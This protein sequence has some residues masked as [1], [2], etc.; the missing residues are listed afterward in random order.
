MLAGAETAQIQV[1][2]VLLGIH[3][4]LG[5]APLEH[6]QALLALGA[7]HDFS[8]AR[9]E[10]VH[11]GHGAPVVVEPH[12]EGLDVLRVIDHERRAAEVLLGE[13]PLVLSLQVDAP[14]DR[15]LEGA[16]GRLGRTQDVDG[17]GVGDARE[18]GGR[19]MVQPLQQP[20][21]DELVQHG[22]L[23]GAAFHH[24]ADDVLEHALGQ[25]HI[26]LKVGEGNLGLHHPELGGMARR[27]GILRAER[28]AERVHV[29]EG[30]GEVLGV[31]LAGHGERGGLAEEVG[32]PIH[33]AGHKRAVRGRGSLLAHKRYL[34]RVDGGHAEHLAGPLAVARR[35]DGRVHVDE[36]AVLE[37]AVD[38]GGG[39]RADAEHGA[40]Q[41]RARPQMLLGAQ[42]LRRGALLL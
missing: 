9:H 21:V 3:V 40:E 7:A 39:H 27:V 38:G 2:A 31:Q 35:D 4:Q 24:V 34:G 36:P 12:V 11:G 32:A 14:L 42:E 20:L 25:L 15:V 19:H 8:D 23:V 28:G 5:D 6:F 26:V 30:H 17:L 33:L 13:E 22:Q 41:V 10:A 16:P 1:G 18:V 37:E 29:P